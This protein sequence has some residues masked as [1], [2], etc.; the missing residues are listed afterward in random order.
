MHKYQDWLK[1]FYPVSHTHKNAAPLRDV[2]YY[3][4]DNENSYYCVQLKE[5]SSEII[6]ITVN[7][8]FYSK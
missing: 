4:N 1:R 7:Q 6:L 5:L 3:F 8:L 2:L